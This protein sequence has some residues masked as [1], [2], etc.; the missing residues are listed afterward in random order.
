MCLLLLFVIVYL[1]LF[2][3]ARTQAANNWKRQAIELLLGKRRWLREL[4][5]ISVSQLIGKLRSRREIWARVLSE[6][7]SYCD[8][9]CLSHRQKYSAPQQTDTQLICR[10][11]LQTVRVLSAALLYVTRTVFCRETFTGHREG[12]AFKL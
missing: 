1:S 10:L 8:R 5:R 4:W 6:L 3:V 12:L 2:S 11:C 7:T 9:L